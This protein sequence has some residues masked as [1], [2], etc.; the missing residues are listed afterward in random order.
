MFKEITISNEYLLFILTFYTIAI[1]LNYLKNNIVIFLTDRFFL[2]LIALITFVNNK[3]VFKQ[4]FLSL[5]IL[6]FCVILIYII[7]FFIYKKAGKTLI[8][9]FSKLSSL[10]ESVFVLFILLF[11]ITNLMV[12]NILFFAMIDI[13]YKVIILSI[14]LHLKK[15]F[16]IQ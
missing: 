13:F 12:I 1:L 2:A 11:G 5:I 9:N 6:S 3:I 7:V 8:L 15:K 14:I 4:V 10:I 16:N